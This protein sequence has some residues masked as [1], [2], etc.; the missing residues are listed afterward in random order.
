MARWVM[1]QFRAFR[2]MGH[3]DLSRLGHV[4]SVLQGR[5]KCM[6]SCAYCRVLLFFS[7]WPIHFQGGSPSSCS[8]HLRGQVHSGSNKFAWR[9]QKLGS[10]PLYFRVD[11]IWSI[12]RTYCLLVYLHQER[13]V[14][15][16]LRPFPPGRY[17]RGC[18][19]LGCPLR[20]FRGFVR[21]VR[22]CLV[23]K[24]RQFKGKPLV[25]E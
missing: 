16:A 8:L 12:L 9:S 1:C 7:S 10:P 4:L 17:T 13:Q 22:D 20:C 3:Q 15:E 2:T 23:L 21:R 11:S 5:W 6:S 18:A 19:G 25:S 24:A 14:V